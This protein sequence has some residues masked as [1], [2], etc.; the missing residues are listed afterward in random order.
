MSS[1]EHFIHRKVVV[2]RH[3]THAQEAARAMRENQIGCVLVSD[4]KGGI[5][6]IVTDRDFACRLAAD[7]QLTNIPIS[8]IMT[9]DPVWAEAGSTVYD[10]IRLMQ[11]HGVRRVPI[12]SMEESSGDQPA[13]RKLVGIVTLDDLIASKLITPHQLSRIVQRQVGRR[14]MGIFGRASGT[15]PSSQARSQA[16]QYQTLTHFYQRAADLTGLPADIVPEFSQFLLGAVLR[17]I[18]YSGAVHL[19]AQLPRALHEFLLSL[20]PGPD[21]DITPRRIVEEAIFRFEFTEDYAWQVVRGFYSGFDQFLSPRQI[22]HLTTQLPDEFRAL[23]RKGE[24]GVENHLKA[25]AGVLEEA[26]MMEGPVENQASQRLRGKPPLTLKCPL[27]VDGGEIPR[28]FTGEGEDQTP[29]LQ[30]S[31][32]P[33]GTREFALL[34]EDPD[35]PTR[36]PWVHWVAFGIS[37]ATSALPE[38]IPPKPLLEAPVRM[39]QGKNSAGKLGYQGPMPPVGHGW[40][41]YYFKLYALDRQVNLPAG[42]DRDELIREILGHVLGEAVLVGRYKRGAAES[43]A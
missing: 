31:H 37:P 25:A 40:H 21:R 10:V 32:I 38:G 8:K 2:L 11:E 3:D 1:I 13:N 19:V 41:R 34:C 36:R 14:L 9:H 24:A 42:A 20:P 4:S 43:A 6:G 18:P 27:F 26:R 30:W 28:R 39:I 29:A 22:D 23:F 12:F 5:S 17:R 7:F 15:T 35:A 33:E 16:H